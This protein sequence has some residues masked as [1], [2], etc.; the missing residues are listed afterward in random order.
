MRDSGKLPASGPGSYRFAEHRRY[1]DALLQQLGVSQRVTLVVRDWG[2]ALGFDWASRHRQA[3]A[4]I[5]YMEAIVRPFTWA[6]WP[7]PGRGIFKALRSPAGEDTIL[8]RNLFV[9]RLLPG[10]VLRALSDEEMD[11]Y[12][13]PFRAVGE[14]RR[15]ILTWPRELPIDG[16]PRD[17]TATV[18]SYG[19]WLAASPVPKLLVNADPG[20]ILTGTHRQRART[21]PSQHEITVPGL[22]YLQED[23]P[24]AISRAIAEWHTQR[25]PS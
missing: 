4:G 16:E 20:A 1:L 22:H 25:H 2:S 21:W 14:D 10:S 5:A 9:E 13:A 17:V 23:S 18:E 11:A 19:T 15:P 6:Q 7:E 3:V 24:H 12:R 8:E